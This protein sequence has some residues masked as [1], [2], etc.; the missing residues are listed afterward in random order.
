MSSS[1]SVLPRRYRLTLWEAA[2]TTLK[3]I[4]ELCEIESFSASFSLNQVPNAAVT[5][6]HGKEVHTDEG[7]TIL[8]HIAQMVMHKTPVL[9][10]LEVGPKPMHMKY[11]E[12]PNERDDDDNELDSYRNYDENNK[13]I[14]FKGYC[15][16]Q[17][18]NKTATTIATTL[19]IVH[20]LFDLTAVSPYCPRSHTTNPYTFCIYVNT[21]KTQELG[22]QAKFWSPL[23]N[24]L[25]K[26]Y[27]SLSDPWS[28]LSEC[29]IALVKNS[30]N[31]ND[32][33]IGS[34]TKLY[35]DNILEILGNGEEGENKKEGRV[36][37]ELKWGE[38]VKDA[39]TR[40]VDAILTYLGEAAAQEWVS[41]T[42]WDAVVQKFASMFY[43][44]VSPTVDHLYV[45]PMPN[46]IPK[47]T[48]E[49]SDNDI[50]NL[51]IEVPTTP[52][53]GGVI[54]VDY[55]GRCAQYGM[56]IYKL[57]YVY[58]PR[59]K[60][61]QSLRQSTG[62]PLVTLE[63]PQWLACNPIKF[64]ITDQANTQTPYTGKLKPGPLMP[65]AER[66]T[67]KCVSSADAV[68]QQLTKFAYLS[69]V[70]V[71]RRMEI[72]MPFR[73]DLL[74]GTAVHVTIYDKITGKQK[75]LEVYGSIETVGLDYGE[76]TA[77][78]TIVLTNLR[79]PV[80]YASSIYNEG[81]VFYDKLWTGYG[82]N[83]FLAE[84]MQ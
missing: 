18:F 20:W 12:E 38:D 13:Y 5:L 28:I 30:N 40:L 47:E 26:N 45:I 64:N 25:N 57:T 16:A 31:T 46:S 48:V 33:L 8:T 76:G 62:G 55:E 9:V 2:V 14:I 82:P 72:T 27:G 77:R 51:H 68:A 66:E 60:S 49:I 35:Q 53:L 84:R 61:E 22:R 75:E 24:N 36:I 81:P 43:F 50:Y 69:K 21:L 15:S 41:T 42:I 54:L 10:V 70:F 80:E 65:D 32:S 78:T 59:L 56:P 3:P 23:I 79:N 67:Q 52:V 58:P 11:S 4:Q 74:P 39:I 83:Y 44:A 73:L 71:G 29:F 6:A 1:L 34:S 7:S 17:S 63:L 37:N 19:H